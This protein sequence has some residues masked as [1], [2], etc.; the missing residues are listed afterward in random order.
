MN[1][2]VEHEVMHRMLRP[3]SALAPFDLHECPWKAQWLH[4]YTRQHQS[5]VPDLG[6]GIEAAM[7]RSICA[8]TGMTLRELIQ[9]SVMQPNVTD[10]TALWATKNDKSVFAVF[11]TVQNQN[12]RTYV[13]RSICTPGAD[14]TY[15]TGIIALIE[16]H[17][18][19]RGVHMVVDATQ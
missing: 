15:R 2:M 4:I 14:G 17:A 7:D 5:A 6:D 3:T 11:Q 18:R 1:V 12:G 8:R 10:V 9:E 13:I 16:T 19:S